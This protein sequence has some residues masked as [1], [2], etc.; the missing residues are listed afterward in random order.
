MF[1]PALPSS[2]KLNP[3]R[4]SKTHG[5]LLVHVFPEW[6]VH[7]CASL[8]RRLLLCWPKL[9]TLR[10][11]S[12]TTRQAKAP[13]IPK[14]QAQVPVW[15]ESHAA[16]ESATAREK[17]LKGWSFAT[18]KQAVARGVLRL[19]PAT[20]NLLGPTRLTSCKTPTSPHSCPLCPILIPTALSSPI[21]PTN[22]VP[23]KVILDTDIGGRH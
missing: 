8:R 12:G 4:A 3:A 7:L 22:A 23:E 5:R 10:N 21:L 6:L 9:T 13:L 17:Q 11:A 18:R 14:P 2:T 1:S 20:G 16:Q 15:Y 19:G